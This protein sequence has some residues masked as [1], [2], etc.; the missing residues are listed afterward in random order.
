MIRFSMVDFPGK[1]ACVV[2]CAHCNFRC[3]FCH[4]PHLV[5]DP[6]SQPRVRMPQIL[7][8]MQSR[9]GKLDGIV[10]SGG[11]PTLDPELPDFAMKMK[12]MGFAVKLDT[13]GSRPELLQSLHDAGC[14]QALGIDYK[15]PSGKYNEIANSGIP[16]LV[17]RVR[18]SLA[19]ALE[20]KIQL[21]VRTTVHKDLLSF[22]DLQTM[23][24]EL[25]A[26]GVRDWNLQQFNP[27][28]TIDEAISKAPTYSEL[29]LV[30]FARKLPRTKVRGLTGIYLD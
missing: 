11:E 26:I 28:D 30:S 8:F 13:N 18:Q 19:F 14:L 23:R 3:A 2:F 25:D 4:N 6:D 15:A 7:H 20:N 16:D 17:E 24:A 21:D 1:I 9:I 12:D 27:V 22:E 10:I 29:E 5:L